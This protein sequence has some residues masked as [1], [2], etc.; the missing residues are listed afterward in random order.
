VKQ[1]A[2]RFPLVHFGNSSSPLY[3]TYS[4]SFPTGVTTNQGVITFDVV[5][6]IAGKTYASANNLAITTPC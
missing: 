5:A 4:V 2:A 6:V 1:V 3:D